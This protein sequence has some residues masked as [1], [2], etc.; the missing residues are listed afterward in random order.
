MNFFHQIR[1][2]F[3]FPL[4]LLLASPKKNSVGGQAIIEGV[5]M[6]GKNK[7]SWAIRKGPKEVL[8]EEQEF[9]SV[10]KKYKILGIPVIRGAVSLFESLAIGYKALSRSADIAVELEE[11]SKQD[12][13]KVEKKKNKVADQAS[14]IFG[15]VL[16]MLISLGIFMY[17]PMWI[18]SQFVPKESALLFNSL[19]GVIRIVFFLTYLI[20]ISQWKEIRRVFEYHGAEH[21]AIFAFEDGKE[22]TIDNMRPYTTLHPRCGTSFLFLVILCCILLF[23]I[24]DAL[25][26]TYI[27]PFPNTLS[28]MLVHLALV[29]LVSGT[30]FEVLKLS[31][32]YQNFPIVRFF[33]K[34][35]LWLQKITTKNPDDTQMETASLALKAAL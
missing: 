12:A 6:R 33:I 17:L 31:D 25:I 24:V 34:P 2:S 30:S 23:S 35:G 5:M 20:L 16:G 28:R 27:A 15:L 26:I 19:S 32:R 7:V 18:L 4:Q 22:L 13:A 29:P 1:N 10:C 8:I 11:Q 21:K 3:L 9:Q 14:S